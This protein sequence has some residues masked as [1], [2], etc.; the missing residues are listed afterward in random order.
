MQISENHNISFTWNLNSV[1]DGNEWVKGISGQY[2]RTNH[3]FEGYCSSGTCLTCMDKKARDTNYQRVDEKVPIPSSLWFFIKVTNKNDYELVT[4]FLSNFDDHNTVINVPSVIT[5]RNLTEIKPEYRELCKQIDEL[6]EQIGA[7]NQELRVKIE[8][9][10][11]KKQIEYNHKY[12]A[13]LNRDNDMEDPV[14]DEYC[15]LRIYEYKYPEYV[16]ETYDNYEVAFDIC[17]REGSKFYDDFL[18]KYDLIE[19]YWPGNI[20]RYIITYVKKSTHEQL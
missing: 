10:Y 15:N 14:Y 3:N 20:D 18:M 11:T 8:E 16:Y 2:G 1:W 17:S 5:K 7:T 4:E 12:D 6:N 19:K 13:L 9:L